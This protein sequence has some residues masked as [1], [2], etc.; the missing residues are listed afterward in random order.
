MLDVPE[1][2]KTMTSE[3]MMA[4][5]GEQRMMI[6]CQ[7]FDDYKEEI[8]TSFPPD[9]SKI[10]TKRCLCERLYGDEVNIGGL[11]NPFALD[12]KELTL[13]RHRSVKTTTLTSK[14]TQQLTS[15]RSKL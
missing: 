14:H 4:L 5:S 9:L 11:L 8:L 7:M 1:N 15:V 10:E 2:Y 12:R 3:E 13:N 6:A